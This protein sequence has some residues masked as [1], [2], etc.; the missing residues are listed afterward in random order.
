L[1]GADQPYR[2]LVETMQE[3][4]AT[5]DADGTVLYANSRFAE[6]LGVPLERFMGVSLQS[7]LA[8]Q[9]GERF[10]QLLDRARR[11]TAK[12]EIEF[13]DALERNRLLHL[14]LSPLPNYASDRE[15]P[16]V[17]VVATDVTDLFEAN[18]A[19]RRNEETLQQLSARLLQSQDAER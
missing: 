12:G 14:A 17:C 2:V 4:A 15:N 8:P 11:E 13:R 7:Q 16:A 5:L 18:E 1:E 6:L 19:L 3:G 10:G 9:V